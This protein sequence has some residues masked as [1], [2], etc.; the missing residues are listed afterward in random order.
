MKLNRTFAS[1]RRTAADA[2]GVSG[3]RRAVAAAPADPAHRVRAPLSAMLDDALSGER[4]IGMI[5]PKAGDDAIGPAPELCE[6]GCVGRIVQ[7]AEIGDGRCFLSLM[8]V[9]RFRI[10]EEM[11]TVTPYRIVRAGLCGL[12]PGFRRGRRRGRRRPRGAAEGAA[13]FRQGQ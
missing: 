8:G 6:V 4:L 5:Q 12:R 1:A 9:S 11:T 3:G 13:R 7:F 10:A 2:A